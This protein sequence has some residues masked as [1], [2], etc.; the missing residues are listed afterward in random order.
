VYFRRSNPSYFQL[1][2]SHHGD[3]QRNT[4]LPTGTQIYLH[5]YVQRA[6]TFLN[7]KLTSASI[8]NPIKYCITYSAGIT[9]TN[10][11]KWLTSS[12]TNYLCKVERVPTEFFGLL[13]GH[14]LDVECP[15]GELSQCDSVVQVA[16][17]VVWVRAGELCSSCWRQVLDTLISLQIGTSKIMYQL[18][19][20]RI[21]YNYFKVFLHYISAFKAN[22]LPPTRRPQSKLSSLTDPLNRQQITEVKPVLYGH[23]TVQ[24]IS[25]RTLPA[26]C[27]VQSQASR[28]R[29]R[30]GKY[31]SEKGF[32]R[33]VRF[34]LSVL[35]HHCC[36]SIYLFITDSMQY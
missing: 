7:F 30:G 33:V 24:V 12:E 36:T 27:R 34:S 4:S 6:N 9:P 31:C 5:T 18:R 22:F 10:Q 29:I 3:D 13:E 20:V 28:C 35:F 23:A 25:G 15:R 16:R 2:K 14:Y 32:L 1:C 17:S 26:E 21:L 8:C 19:D 11:N